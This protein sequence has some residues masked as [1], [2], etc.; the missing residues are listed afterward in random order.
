MD[1]VAPMVGHAEGASFGGASTMAMPAPMPPMMARESAVSS[2][3]ARDGNAGFAGGGGNADLAG[4][5][6][7]LPPL[8]GGDGK[9]PAPGG[10]PEVPQGSLLIKDGSM[11][12]RVPL[13]GVTPLLDGI[14][15]KM[16]GLGG[17]V[18]SSSTY[19]DE[20]LLARLGRAAA[21][22]GAAAP[23]PAGPTGANVQVRVPAAKFD[24]ARAA[25][26]QLAE[27]GG[28]TVASESM[29]T[30]DATGQWVD[31]VARLRVQEKTLARMSALLG[32]AQ[33][34]HEAVTVEQEL[35]RLTAGL[36]SLTSQRK[37]LEGR[38]AMSSLSVQV[39]VPEPAQATPTPQP[40]P[41]W[42]GGATMRA[43]LG[44]LATAGTVAADVAIYTAVYALPVS[45][46]VL[47]AGLV[48]RRVK[49]AAGARRGGGRGGDS[50]LGGGGSTTV[51]TE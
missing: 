19:S 37:W 49:L 36:E 50:G 24:A 38:A 8:S 13:P 20:W 11:H 40:S 3:M 2:A 39:S 32:A 48:A 22:G 51:V 21:S 41:S 5:L 42:S 27:A 15:T 7:K 12:L 34:V 46:L 47:L 29:N 10:D 43:A 17:Y 18:E 14:A 26:R 44:S 31:V 4:V 33:S 9:E 28:G 16:A 45:A 1:M 25:L 6:S 23:A 35:A 30:Q